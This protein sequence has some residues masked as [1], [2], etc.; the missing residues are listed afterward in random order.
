MVYDCR[1][2]RERKTVQNNSQFPSIHVHN[3]LPG[4]RAQIQTS[5]DAPGSPTVRPP[6]PPPTTL[7][8]STSPLIMPGPQTN[9][10]ADPQPRPTPTCSKPVIDLTGSDDSYRDSKFVVGLTDPKFVIDLTGSDDDDKDHGDYIIYPTVPTMLV[11]LDAEYPALGFMQF[12]GVL[13]KN[14]FFYVSQ[15]VEGKVEQQLKEME[16]PPGAR[17]LLLDRAPRLMRRAGKIYYLQKCG[18]IHCRVGSSLPAFVGRTP[19]CR[20][21]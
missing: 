13:T 15:F 21:R 14:G 6:F 10:L 4:S 16:I 7:K 8:R 5:Y 17:N 12:E 2:R 18:E 11:E 20:G 1:K 3:H 19:P 9:R